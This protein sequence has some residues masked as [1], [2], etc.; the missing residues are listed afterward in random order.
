LPKNLEAHDR[1]DII[2]RDLLGVQVRGE[3]PEQNKLNKL[4]IILT[5]VPFT[6]ALPV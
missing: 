1:K 6:K 2:K 4:I 3:L 5:I